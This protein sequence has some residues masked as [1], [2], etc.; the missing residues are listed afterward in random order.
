MA[1]QAETRTGGESVD[2]K[3]LA[4]A[5][6]A[7]LAAAI[8]TSTFWSRGALVSAALTPVIISLV[9]E[10]LNRHAA[11][12]AQPAA[13][14]VTAPVKGVAALAGV[15]AG[16]RGAQ[17]EESDR[18]YAEPAD[19]PD[20]NPEYASNGN[21]GAPNGSIPAHADDPAHDQPV[22]GTTFW[23][24]GG[25]EPMPAD[26]GASAPAAGQA[27]GTIYRRGRFRLKLALLT[28]LAA[29][30]IAVAALTLPELVFG[31]SVTGNGGGTTL[32][33]GGE[34]SGQNQDGSTSPTE[35]GSSGGVEG[36]VDPAD[37]EAQSVAPDGDAAPAPEE[38]APAE[39]AEPAPE[40]PAPEE[41]APAPEEPVEPQ[42]APAPA[43]AE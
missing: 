28:G 30:L 1:D 22:E 39:P 38:P 12:V 11:K 40:E 17:S 27:G 3:T 19:D 2:L 16:A 33:G 7:A 8:V 26:Y 13:R 29:F 10:G 9:K 18:G 31:G 25:P 41:P 21:G 6:A 43:P 35:D 34:R 36:E 14:V 5:A 37:P 4:I 42:S 20:R 24:T 23:P 32:F 15:G